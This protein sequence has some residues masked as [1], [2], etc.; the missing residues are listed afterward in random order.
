MKRK[1]N[2]AKAL[3]TNN[4]YSKYLDQGLV[5]SLKKNL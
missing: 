2:Q 5:S 3:S 4:I 1:K